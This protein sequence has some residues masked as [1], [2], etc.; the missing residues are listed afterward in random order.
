VAIETVIIFC[1]GFGFMLLVLQ[2]GTPTVPCC[3]NEPMLTWGIHNVIQAPVTTITVEID[4][5][6]GMP[7]PEWTL[8]EASAALFH[9]RLSGLRETTAKH[10]SK[11]L[12]Y[13]GLV[14]R[15]SQETSLT[16]YIQ[17]GL[18]EI[19][20]GASSTFFLDE[21]RSLER[22]LIGTGRK[23]LSHEILDVIDADLQK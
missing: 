18:I 9:S 19:S 17:N 1:V 22:W 20:D 16:L 7:N 2:P 4:I 21:Q 15:M 6:S 8:P 14:I 5:F 12:G 23:F 13:R 10:R 11:N 3:V